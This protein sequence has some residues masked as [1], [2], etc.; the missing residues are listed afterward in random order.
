M[1]NDDPDGDVGERRME[2]AMTGG[3]APPMVGARRWVVGVRIP[4]SDEPVR[5]NMA[6]TRARSPPRLCCR[7]LPC[8]ASTPQSLDPILPQSVTHSLRTVMSD[9]HGRIG[10]SRLILDPR[11]GISSHV[12]HTIAAPFTFILSSQGEGERT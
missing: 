9:S 4:R 8:S 2:R 10:S 7:L 11:S 5:V 1:E 6:T 12:H 3:R